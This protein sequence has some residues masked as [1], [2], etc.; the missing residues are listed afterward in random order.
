MGA[1]VTR[2]LRFGLPALALTIFMGCEGESPLS[3]D[4]A[5]V[6][7]TGATNN[8]STGLNG[9]VSSASGSV[10][11]VPGGSPQPAAPG[12]SPGEASPQPG[13]SDS[14]GSP[15]PGASPGSGS[16]TP[17][18]GTPAT[19][20]PERTPFVREIAE[21]DT[22]FNSESNG[23]TQIQAAIGSALG[24]PSSLAGFPAALSGGAFVL[25][26][27]LT[28][29]ELSL[30]LR[31]TTL[32]VLASVKMSN[33]ILSSAYRL[34]GFDNTLL[35]ASGKRLRAQRQ[36][37]QSLVWVESLGLSDNGQTASR[38]FPVVVSDRSNLSLSVDEIDNEVTEL[39]V[40]LGALAPRTF[41]VTR[42]AITPEDSKATL[43]F[44]D[45]APGEYALV[46]RAKQSVGAD[47]VVN[48]SIT[49]RKNITQYE[50][51]S[52]AQVFPFK[53]LALGTHADWAGREVAVTCEGVAADA[54]ILVGGTEVA[55]SKRES[56]VSKGQTILFFIV[57]ASLT[58]GDVQVQS[59][60]QTLSPPDAT[61]RRIKRVTIT[62][63]TASVVAGATFNFTM[64]ALDANNLEI[65]PYPSS[66]AP[67]GIY[68]ADRPGEVASG[69]NRVGDFSGSGVYK[70]K[71]PG[72]DLILVG[73]VVGPS[74]IVPHVASDELA[75]ATVTVTANP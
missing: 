59:A 20:T 15:S 17:D 8:G 38:S 52:V 12:A 53:V 32:D 75:I 73:K 2:F 69:F 14:A 57:P 18:P 51:L 29:D 13:P 19:P 6:P 44:K 21:F 48:K 60:G 46:A 9:S 36:A 61:F 16:A 28:D 7:R 64:K 70:A 67:F 50:P 74:T 40:K 39:S 62:P 10:T 25:G 23:F 68:D 31:P 27:S 1:R 33:G 34:A 26:T 41:S 24:L 42:G 5:G 72:R 47:I 55:V 65:S 56:G 45:L 30:P 35:L 37:G 63:A 71:A 22:S 11:P 4:P 66:K 3:I 54:R 49:V 43:D 58:E